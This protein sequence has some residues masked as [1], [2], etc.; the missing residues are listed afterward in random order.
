M[1][2]LLILH[3]DKDYSWGNALSKSAS[4]ADSIPDTIFEAVLACEFQVA[5]DQVLGH[6]LGFRRGGGAY[7]AAIAADISGQGQ[8]GLQIGDRRVGHRAWR[9]QPSLAP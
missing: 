6:L 3:H 7:C 4:A 8:F 1:V 2:R 9:W 5:V